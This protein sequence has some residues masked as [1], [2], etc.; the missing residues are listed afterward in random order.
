M[1]STARQGARTRGWHGLAIV[2]ALGL[3]GGEALAGSYLEREMDAELV[4]APVEYAVLVPEDTAENERLPLVLSLHGGGGSRDALERQRPIW[5]ALWE[6]GRV[7]PMVV[8]MPS[9]TERSFYMDFA[10]GSEKWESFILGPFIAHLRDSLPVSHERR[11]TFVMGISM[12]GMGGLRM[13]FKHP[14]AFAA[15]AALEPGIEPVLAWEDVRPKHRFWRDDALFERAFGSPV[16]PEYW[17]ANNPATIANRRAARLRDAGLAIYLEAGDE[18]EFW[19]YE[20]AEFLHRVLWEAR[21]RHEYHLVR[22]AGHVDESLA[23]RQA[24]AIMFLARTLEPWSGPPA[25]LRGVLRWVERRK[26]RLDER[27]HYGRLP[28]EDGEGRSAGER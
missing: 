22:G 16:D 9:V 4:P 26:A 6:R 17:A 18:D 24:E 25:A 12:G 20:G 28:P 14:G 15:V 10:D 27:D 13:A 1:E 23:E 11:R 8:A 5:E 2:A 19:L 21:I 7:P 3:W